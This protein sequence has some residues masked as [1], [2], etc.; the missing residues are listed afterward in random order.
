MALVELQ[1]RDIDGYR[2]DHVPL[3][4]PRGNL[5]DRL[6]DDGRADFANHARVFGNLYELFRRQQPALRVHPAH[7]RFHAAQGAGHGVDPRLVIHDEFVPGDRAPQG[8]LLAEPV[9]QAVGQTGLVEGEAALAVGLGC[10]KRQVG[11]LEQRV[12]VGTVARKHRHPDRGLHRMQAL[13]VDFERFL[14]GLDDQARNPGNVIAA[15]HFLQ[16]DGKFVAAQAHHVVAGPHQRLQP[17]RRVPQQRVACAVAEGI[18][19]MP[20]VV[21]VDKQQGQSRVAGAGRLDRR[22]QEF[23]QPVPVRQARQRIGV[24]HVGQRLLLR[25]PVGNV[26]HRHRQA[27]ARAHQ[28]P[29]QPARAQRSVGRCQDLVLV[30][31]RLHG[32]AEHCQQLLR[33]TT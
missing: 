19:D 1:G 20:E 23:H 30:V 22:G 32:G 3:Q 21:E 11:M 10:I 12:A 18:V 26:A 9:Q 33:V 7:Q 17:R 27:R 16:H 25:A 5:G 24:G 15:L 28:A 8:L 4:L 31:A 29:R 14:H 13:P 2:H 6:F